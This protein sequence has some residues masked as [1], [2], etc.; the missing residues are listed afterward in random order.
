[1]TRLDEHGEAIIAFIRS[2][3]QAYHCSPSYEEIGAAVGLPSK[4]HVSRD[5]RKLK[6]HGYLSFTPGMSRSIVLRRDSRGRTRGGGAVPIPVV[7][8]IPDINTDTGDRDNPRNSPIDWVTV[9]RDLV[10]DDHDV[11]VWRVRGSSMLDALV[12]DGDLVVIKPK[13]TAQNGEMIAAWLKPQQTMTLKYYHHEDGH[14]RL[15]PAN[16]ALPTVQVRPSDI[17]IQGQVLAIVRK[18]R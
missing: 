12:N 11:R 17:E 8:V 18:A 7:G 3:Q 14:V 10:G 15:Q 2:Y 6:E 5:L 1:M 16:P 4:D 13:N 9:A